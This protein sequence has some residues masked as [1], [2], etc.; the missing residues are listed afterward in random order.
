MVVT[1]LWRQS[2]PGAAVNRS[3]QR[4]PHCG[5]CVGHLISCVGAVVRGGIFS[6]SI[7]ALLRSAL[8]KKARWAGSRFSIQ[9]KTRD[10]TLRGRVGQVASQT[11]CLHCLHCL[12]LCSPPALQTLTH[13]YTTID[14]S[15]SPLPAI[16]VHFAQFWCSRVR[17]SSSE[18]SARNADCG[19]VVAPHPISANPDLSSNPIAMSIVWLS[20]CIT[21]PMYMVISSKNE[22]N[23]TCPT[24]YTRRHENI[25]SLSTGDPANSGLSSTQL[26]IVSRYH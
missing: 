9:G 25:K 16:S 21:L 3:A 6:G 1:R 17:P 13:F 18:S 11:T 23:P 8:V 15:N 10:L 2:E 20:L 22:K 14:P 7:T 5:C 19:L 4:R 24:R 12:H 26:L